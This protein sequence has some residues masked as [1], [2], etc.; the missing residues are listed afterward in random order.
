MYT[1]PNDNNP[2]NA[3]SKNRRNTN[4]NVKIVTIIVLGVLVLALIIGGMVGCYISGK[5]SA[6][7]SNIKD[8]LAVAN[9]VYT[10]I[11]KYYYQERI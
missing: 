7:N 11:K 5:N 2:H 10:L 8:E 4:Y 6:Y 1:F 3:D 9:E